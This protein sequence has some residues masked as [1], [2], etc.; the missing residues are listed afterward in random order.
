MAKVYIMQWQMSSI[1][2]HARI[3]AQRLGGCLLG[4]S[5]NG[6]PVFKAFFCCGIGDNKVAANRSPVAVFCVY[7]TSDHI[8]T[9][10]EVGNSGFGELAELRRGRGFQVVLYNQLCTVKSVIVGMAGGIGCGRT[11]GGRG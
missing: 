9:I 3:A 2:F 11:A 5:D 6:V 8:F 1:I 4:L 7:P 10:S